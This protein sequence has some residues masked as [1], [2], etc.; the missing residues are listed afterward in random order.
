MSVV[1]VACAPP[2]DGTNTVAINRFV[3]FEYGNT[4][5]Y[6]CN[7]GYEYSGVLDSNCQSDGS[8]SLPPPIC[9]GKFC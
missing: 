6:V 9:V 4:Y 1:V 3:S 5:T 7:T 2:P 8:W